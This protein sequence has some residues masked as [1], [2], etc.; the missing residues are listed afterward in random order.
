MKINLKELKS[1]IFQLIILA[2]ICLI[3]VGC[4]AFFISTGKTFKIGDLGSLGDFFGGILNPIFSFLGFLALLTT[5]ILQAS[6]LKATRK[7]L[8]KSAKAQKEQS[9]S[10]KLQNK[11]TKLQMFENTFFQLISLFCTTRDNFIINI[12]YSPRQD[13]LLN[14]YKVSYTESFKRKFDLDISGV[15]RSVEAI[16]WYLK[17]LKEHYILA[18]SY[19]YT[20][21]NKE[22][23]E[24]TGAYFG[25]AYQILKFIDNSNIENRQRYVNIFRAQFTKDELEF[26]FYH[27]LGIIGK[28]KF[29][30]LV[31]D[32][33]FF[34]H[35][36]LNDNIKKQL[37]EYDEKAFGNNE[38]ILEAYNNLKK[39][40]V[41]GE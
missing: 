14:K 33:E 34:E 25:Q 30:K 6:E 15:Y 21:F 10:S 31:E 36:I 29:K 2:L 12:E 28:R 16:K 5:I 17:S 23:E 37:L 4:I 22:N 35:I 19:D 38:K 9:E 24:Y 18:M 3:V 39:E 11:A 40:A 26:L 20:F 8:K 1:N 27:C 41:T 32:Y 13:L 7:E